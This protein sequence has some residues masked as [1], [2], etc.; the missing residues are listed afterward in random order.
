ML[1]DPEIKTMSRSVL[2]HRP[3]GQPEPKRQVKIPRA[4]RVRRKPYMPDDQAF[5]HGSVA[6][7][8][9]AHRAA[10]VWWIYLVLGMITAMGLLWALQTLIHFGQTTADDLRYGRPRTTHV[11]HFVGHETGKTPSHFVAMNLNGAIYIIE[12][13]GGNPSSSRLLVGPHLKGEGAELAPVTL[14][15]VG[16]QEHPDLLIETGGIQVRF[17]NNG[18]AYEA[19]T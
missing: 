10:L 3:I 9:H 4:S 18:S 1:A 16:D 17:R 5:G 15:F 8:R 19:E 12:M 6:P 13:P 7:R 14:S 2:R 11:D